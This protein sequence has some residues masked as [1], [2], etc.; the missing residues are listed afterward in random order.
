MD[1]NAAVKQGL[2]KEDVREDEFS[3]LKLDGALTITKKNKPGVSYK[4]S[5][6]CYFVCI[7]CR[8]GW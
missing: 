5:I 7:F 1:Y 4:P 8:G 3:S 6:S 2:Q